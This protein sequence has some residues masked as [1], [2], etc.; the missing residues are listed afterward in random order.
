MTRNASKQ[1]Y[2]KL[3]FFSALMS[4]ILKKKEKKSE[5]KF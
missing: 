2:I 1:C 4:V 5:R 3:D